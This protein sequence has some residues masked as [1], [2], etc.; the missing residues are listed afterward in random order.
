MRTIYA[1]CRE[2]DDIVDHPADISIRLERLQSWQREL[3]SAFEG[4]SR[5]PLLLQVAEVAGRFGIPRVHFHELIEGVGMDLKQNRYQSFDELRVYCYHV[6]SSVGLM[7]LGI[8]GSRDERTKEYAVNLGIA[9][10]LTNILRDVGND[11]SVGR[12]Y[13]PQDD[14][15]AHGCTEEDV[16]AQRYTPEFRKL[17]EFEAARAGEYFR[18]ADESLPSGERGLMFP[19]RIMQRVYFDTLQRIKAA[20]YNVFGERVSVPRTTQLLIALRCWAR[21]R[22][23]GR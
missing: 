6:A 17:M 11:A 7:C 21:H 15:A 16:L 12:I 23:L 8:F 19:A 13:L 10:Q 9:L 2:T 18:K 14:L 22:L 3:A 5:T 1:F 4:S 20:G